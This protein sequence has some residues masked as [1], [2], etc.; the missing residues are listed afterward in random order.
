MSRVKQM[1][2]GTKAEVKHKKKEEGTTLWSTEQ[3][4][5]KVQQRLLVVCGIYNEHYNCLMW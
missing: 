1:E 2:T 5:F 3:S 4:I